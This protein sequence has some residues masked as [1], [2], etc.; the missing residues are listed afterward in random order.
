VTLAAGESIADHCSP[1]D[2]ALVQDDADWWTHFVGEDGAVDSYDEPFPSYNK[3]LW[4]AKAAA[5]FSGE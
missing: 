5:E 1:G 4:T 2:I 3:A